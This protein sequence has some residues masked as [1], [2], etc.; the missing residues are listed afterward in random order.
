LGRCRHK[1]GCTAPPAIAS[2]P[3]SRC[4]PRQTRRPARCGRVRPSVSPAIRCGPGCPTLIRRAIHT[5][6]RAACVSRMS[7]GLARRAVSQRR[8]ASR[9]RAALHDVSPAACGESGCERL[10]RVPRRSESA[11]RHSAASPGIRHHARP[12]AHL[13]E[14]PAGS[15]ANEGEGRFPVDASRYVLARPTQEPRLPHLPH[16]GGP[17]GSPHVRGPARL[18]DLPSPVGG[19]EQLRAMPC[20]GRARTGA[21][22]GG[23]DCG[24]GAPAPRSFR[25]IQARATC[26]SGLR[27]VPHDA[28]FA[29]HIGARE[30]VHRLPRGPP[31]GTAGL[32]AVSRGDG[33]GASAH[34]GD[35]CRLRCLP[36]GEH[37]GPAGSRSR[38]LP[39]VP[40][41]PA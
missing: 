12:A 26:D 13:L 39:H 15:R 6:R 22:R 35:A 19:D 31:R 18:S 25:L 10:Q 23:A 28:R 16:V 20:A 3:T 34:N 33:A 7:R 24:G 9:G 27:D 29:R 37:G 5:S 1:R 21:C 38:P 4:S 2:P 17:A 36:S 32:R 30:S 41:R 11:Q 14:P 40:H 8:G